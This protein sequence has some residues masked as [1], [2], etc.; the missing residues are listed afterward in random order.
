MRLWICHGTDEANHFIR[1]IAIVTE[2]KIRVT[3]Y[4]DIILKRQSL[5]NTFQ[6]N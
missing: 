2:D 3:L 6:T 1:D 4:K 5:L